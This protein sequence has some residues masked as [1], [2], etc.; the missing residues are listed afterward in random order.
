MERI[1]KTNKRANESSKGKYM[2]QKMSGERSGGMRIDDHK[3]WAGGPNKDSVLSEGVK[4]KHESPVMGAGNL[5]R[6]EDTTEAIKSQ[7][8]KSISKIHGHPVKPEYR[9]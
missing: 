1:K 3:F 5:S 8:E 7:Q 4:N 9:N 2:S 6:Y